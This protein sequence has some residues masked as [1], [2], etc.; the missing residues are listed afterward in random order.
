MKRYISTLCMML[1][2]ALLMTS[3]LKDDEEDTTQYYNNTAISVFKLSCINRYVH[4]TTSSGEDSVYKK[5][6]TD[7]VVFTID[8]AQHKIYN[9][10]S[11]PSD[12]DLTHILATINSINAGTI[13]VNYPDK[14]GNDSL[15]YYNSTDSIDFTK[16]KD[17]RVYSQEGS[18]FRSYEV[19]INVHKT[20]TGKMIWEQKTVADLPTDV[21]KALWEEKA[22]AAGMKQ[23]IGYGSAEGYAFGT[24]GM[25]MVSKDNGETWGT[26]EID[27]DA[28]WLPT[29][30]IA[31]ASWPFTANDSTDYQLLIGTNDKSD[32]ACIVWRKIAEYA[33]NSLPSKWVLIPTEA[34]QEYYLP[35]MDNLNL[36]HFNNQVMAIGNNR[37]I[38]VSRDQGITWKTTTK[39]TLPEA[40][41]TNNLSA[42]TDDNGYLWLIGKDTGEVWR[43][44]IIE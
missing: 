15:L 39:Y 24:D 11:L 44:L 19:T 22:T 5:T 1:A 23:L 20:E 26:D 37:S 40:L 18:T 10:D 35:K 13:V 4:T 16:L 17:L 33:K 41:G 29:A 28:A 9:T 21:K 25:L 27:E 31:F 7:P 3:C 38:Y 30:N 32:K 14:N 2:G 8:Q 6:L 43:G 42:T 36:V 34:Q 12:C